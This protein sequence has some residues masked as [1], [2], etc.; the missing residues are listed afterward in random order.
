MKTIIRR[1]EQPAPTEAGFFYGVPK[2]YEDQSAIAPIMV[3]QHR[4]TKELFGE[5]GET[6]FPIAMFRW[7][8]PVAELVEEKN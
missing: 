5:V 2:D 7:F 6:P 4:S 1:T 8:G 3:K